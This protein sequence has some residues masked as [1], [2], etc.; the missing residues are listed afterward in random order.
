MRL[1]FQHQMGST[2]KTTDARGEKRG[3]AR[4]GRFGKLG[5]MG[6]RWGWVSILQGRGKT[7]ACASPKVSW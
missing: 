3:V 4:E 7:S 6:G 5:V 2:R 1:I